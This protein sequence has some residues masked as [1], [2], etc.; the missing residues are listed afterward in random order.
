MT[1]VPGTRL[2]PYE[3]VCLVG[4]GGMGHVYKARDSRLQRDVAIKLL[5]RESLAQWDFHS[6]LEQE[7]A[8]AAAVTHPHICTLYDI[9]LE[10]DAS[11]LIMEYLEG[12]TLAARLKRGPLELTEAV[13]LGGQ[14][15]EALAA[16]HA[17]NLIHCD[18]K[19]SN[20]MLTET[21]AKLLDFGLAKVRVGTVLHETPGALTATDIGPMGMLMGTL[22]YMSPEQIEGR[23]VDHRADIFAFGAVLHEMITGRSVF[24]GRSRADIIAT[25]LKGD[26][27]LLR[28]RRA[29]VPPMLSA[30]VRTCLAKEPSYR[31]QSAADVATSLRTI[32]MALA[33][34]R[35][36]ASSG[37][38]ASRAMRSLVV[39]PLNNQTGDPN[40]QY[41]ADGMTE[42]LISS[43]SI[44]GQLKIISRSS[45]MKYRDTA[46]PLDQIA[47][48]LGVDG[49]IRGSVRRSDTGVGVTVALLE[50]L[51]SDPVWSEEYDRPLTD[52]FRVQGEIAETIAAEIY[53]KLTATERRRFRS[54]RSTSPE[55]NEAYLRGRYYWNRETPEAL[56]RS[57]QYLSVA[58][59]RDPEYAAAHA[60]L[61]DWYLSAGNNGLLPIPES[62]AKAKTSALRALE[63]DPGLAEAYACLGRIAMHECDIQRARAEFETSLRLNPNLVEPVVWSARALS[64]LALFDEA[65]VRVERA[66]QLDPVSPRPYLSA[67]AV[68]YVSRNYEPAMEEGRRALEFEPRL[69]VAFYFIGMAQ[70]HLRRF[71][72]AIHSLKTAVQVGHQHA[73]AVA[74]LGVALARSGRID[75]TLSLIEEMKDRATRAEIS[76]YFFAEVYLALGDVE[77][78]LTYLQRSYELRIPDMAG[79]AVDPLFDGLRDRPEFKKIV[80]DL[81]VTPRQS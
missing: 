80:R 49:I 37:D 9:R 56:D 60:A 25:I 77:R 66:K 17:K 68:C 65:T 24:A 59:Q 54:H 7:A 12:E 42:C 34:R 3:I 53:L 22:Q 62:L 45:A 29:Y 14:I 75:D 61:A 32:A 19:P 8:A 51:K 69:P 73:A 64:Y 27:P 6:R 31:W 33:R 18:L 48:E 40:Q 16:A 50:P 52:L 44:I 13:L 72:D 10:G 43:M 55:I 35:S 39:L 76:P 15:A 78:A 1:L 57:F 28:G 11:F 23:G 67:S 74:G 70:L 63:L 71:D 21:G 5:R 47:R 20:V 36:D 30:L 79:I 41:L 2:G 46:K 26:P 4:T 81:A 38:R 58:V